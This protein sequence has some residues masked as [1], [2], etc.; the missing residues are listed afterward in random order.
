MAMLSILGEIQLHLINQEDELKWIFNKYHDLSREYAG[1]MYISML[2]IIARIWDGIDNGTKFRVCL[3]IN[4]LKTSGGSWL[5]QISLFNNEADID[6]DLRPAS[7]IRSGLLKLAS[8]E[9]ILSLSL[10]LGY[11]LIKFHN[12]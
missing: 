4:I 9:K 7:P 12:Q 8:A 3:H 5:H 6:T 10:I 11:L 2:K 1:Q